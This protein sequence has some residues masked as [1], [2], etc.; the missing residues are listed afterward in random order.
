MENGGGGYLMVERPHEEVTV[1]RPWVRK[2]SE[3]KGGW[4]QWLQ[5][6]PLPLK[7]FYP[8]RAWALYD[9]ISEWDLTWEDEEC[10]DCGM[11]NTE[12]RQHFIWLCPSLRS[13][14][15]DWQVAVGR[16]SILYGL[17]PDRVC[18]TW[19]GIILRGRRSVLI[20]WTVPQNIQKVQEM[21][22]ADKVVWPVCLGVGPFKG[23]LGPIMKLGIKEGPKFIAVPIVITEPALFRA[24]QWAVACRE[25]RRQ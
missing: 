24:P 20:V 1:P 9:Q 10:T 13:R 21:G 4:G 2:E 7:E 15:W 19:G 6:Q 17:S 22:Q 8:L 14:V 18:L 23:V 5:V 11:E 3:S 16:L 25:S 12:G